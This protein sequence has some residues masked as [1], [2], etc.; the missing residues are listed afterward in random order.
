MTFL[1]SI[2]DRKI[3]EYVI[4]YGYLPDLGNKIKI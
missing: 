2:C 1:C 3:K 4:K